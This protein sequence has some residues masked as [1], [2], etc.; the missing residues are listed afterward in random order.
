VN[1]ADLEFV[2]ANGTRAVQLGSGE[3]IEPIGS[4]PLDAGIHL[5]AGIARCGGLRSIT[6]LPEGATFLSPNGRWLGI[7][8]PAD[9]TSLALYDTT[10]GKRGFCFEVRGV[11]DVHPSGEMVVCRDDAGLHLLL[12]DGQELAS[13]SY[14][15]PVGPGTRFTDGSYM[16]ALLFSPC[17][18]YL[19]FAYTPPDEMAILLLLRCPTLEVLDS[20]AP[21]F[22][23]RGYYDHRNA[24]GE[25][26]ADPS[27]GSG[28]VALMRQGGS[29]FLTLDFFSVR[30]D[31]I[32]HAPEHIHASDE[33]IEDPCEINFA[34]DGTRFLAGDL[35]F[36][37]YSFP[38]CEVLAQTVGNDI[39]RNDFIEAFAYSGEHVLVDVEGEVRVLRS[40]DLKAS[41]KSLGKVQEVLANGMVLT[42]GEGGRQLQAFGLETESLPVVAELDSERNQVVAVYHLHGGVWSNVLAEVGWVELNF[43]L[44]D[45]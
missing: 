16:E 30:G 3:R 7:L 33:K 1:V 45:Y 21:P 29:T 28:H 38:G 19:W 10:T 44:A 43:E 22:D 25:V 9:W 31:R 18:E 23:P 37:E 5:V 15:V 42:Q 40:G 24:W 11:Q 26:S 20:C 14:P 6:T 27:P 13:A 36:T 8:D 2:Q 41:V 39:A 35:F 12:P 34:P 4:L 17:G 32:L